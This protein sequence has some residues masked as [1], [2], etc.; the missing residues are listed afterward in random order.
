M[1]CG[2]D[3]ERD[4]EEAEKDPL[5]S[6]AR[7]KILKQLHDTKRRIDKVSCSNASG[8]AADLLVYLDAGAAHH[9]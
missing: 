1:L 7:F 6:D 3:D 4:L 5:Y 2:E 8:C 9:V